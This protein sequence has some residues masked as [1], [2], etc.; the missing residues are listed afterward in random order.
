M[1]TPAPPATPWPEGEV[2]TE[3]ATIRVREVAPRQA[4]LIIDET[5]SSFIDLDHPE[6][7]EFEYMQHMDAALATHMGTAPVRA[8][9]LGGG[10][11]CLARAWDATRPGSAQLA[12]EWDPG[13]A[14][15]VREWFPLPRSPR[16]RI[17]TEDARDAL[18]GFPDERWDVVVRDVFVRGE[19]PSHLTDDGAWRGMARVV[20]PGGLVLTN[21]VDRGALPLARRDAARALRFL[22]H[23]IAIADPAVLKGRRYG[24]VVIAA[25]STAIDGV[26]LARRIHG[27]PMPARILAGPDLEQFARG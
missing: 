15:L 7:L 10:A 26:D 12:V 13:I 5:E 18:D 20:T 27:L 2:S 23:A 11:C 22:G 16:L 21:I 19:V 4:M 25:S 14:E 8:L 9:H 17:R 6:H 1:L 3:I 24:N